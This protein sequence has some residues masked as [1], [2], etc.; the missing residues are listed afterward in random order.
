MNQFLWVDEPIQLLG[1]IL[2]EMEYL[3]RRLADIKWQVTF[4]EKQDIPKVKEKCL[5][6]KKKLAEAKRTRKKMKKLLN[7]VDGL[8]LG[9]YTNEKTRGKQK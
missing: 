1:R 8:L 6:I 9:H 2:D 4:L 7:E 5:K 3:T